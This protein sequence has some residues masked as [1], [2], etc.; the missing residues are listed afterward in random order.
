MSQD[1]DQSIH[2]GTGVESEKSGLREVAKKILKLWPWLYYSIVYKKYFRDQGLLF[3]KI[4]ASKKYDLIVEFHTVGS[5]IGMK[6]AKEWNAAFSVIFDSPVDEQFVEMYGT[7]TSHWKKIQSSERETMESAGK[8][9]CYSPACKEYLETKYNIQGEINVLPSL[10]NKPVDFE[11]K[12]TETFNIGF[13]GSF[14][15]WHKLDMMVRVFHKFHAEHSDTRLFLI[16]YG[17]EWHNI[18]RLVD[19]LNLNDAVEMPGFVSEEELSVYKS[20]FTVAVMPGSNW[21]GSPL[22][23]FEY[24][25]AGIPFISPVSKTVSYVFKEHENCLFVK[26]EDEPGSLLT[27]LDFLYENENARNE[28]GAQTCEYVKREFG[29]QKYSVEL[30]KALSA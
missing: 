11:Q 17:Q 14:L 13:I 12:Q 15:S 8:I 30:I 25:Q 10:L 1:A 23:L 21:Y 4:S 24:A 2:K 5:T 28:M 26:K 16:G 29:P 19:Q 18:R 7:K 27:A 3:S 9:M 6:L 22:K 20:R